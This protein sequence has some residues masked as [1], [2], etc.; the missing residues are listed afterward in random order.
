[1]PT[2]YTTFKFLHVAAVIVW[3]GGV[4]AVSI[5]NARVSREQDA[6]VMASLGQASRFFG[7][8][9]VGPAAGLTLVAGIVMVATGGLRFATLWIAWGLAGMLV[10]SALG[11][12]AIRRAGEALGE[13]LRAGDTDHRRTVSLQNRLRALNIIN[14]LVL[15]SVVAAMVF[16][17]TL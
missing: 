7:G 16:K 4:L 11:G 3:I 5:L 1:M 2:V 15:F 6:S 14:L 12:T 10:S 17:P 13:S 8:A 9:V